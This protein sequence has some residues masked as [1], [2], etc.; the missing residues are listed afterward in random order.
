M[1]VLLTTVRVSIVTIRFARAVQ[2]MST[3]YVSVRALGWFVTVL[4]AIVTDRPVT[5]VSVLQEVAAI[6]GCVKHF[7]VPFVII[8][9][10]EVLRLSFLV[11]A[12][13]VSPAVVL[14]REPSGTH[15][16]AADL[17][18]FRCAVR[19]HSRRVFTV[20]VALVTDRPAIT[21]GVL[22]KVASVVC[23]V[24]HLRFAV[25]V[26]GAQDMFSF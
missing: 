15:I 1:P 13:P 22:G 16:L 12:V 6:V 2:V 18:V 17:L 24:V 21:L 5:T 20:F 23:E 14:V 7:G 11:E 26:I 9:T 10:K 19:R 8:R 3:V 4:V 25:I